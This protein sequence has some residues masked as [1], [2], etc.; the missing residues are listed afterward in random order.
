MKF[1][2]AAQGEAI[3]F[4][5]FRAFI[6]LAQRKV[7][8]MHVRVAV[9]TAIWIETLFTAPEGNYSISKMWKNIFPENVDLMIFSNKQYK[10]LNKYRFRCGLSIVLLKFIC[11]SLLTVFFFFSS[12]DIID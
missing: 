3:Y 1:C 12:L 6:F 2:A 4:L 8:N 7:L 5:C 11:N 9:V 10:P